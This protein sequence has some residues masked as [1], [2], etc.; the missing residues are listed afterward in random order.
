[1][2]RLMG[3]PTVDLLLMVCNLLRHFPYYLVI[4]SLLFVTYDW[5]GDL[6]QG[7]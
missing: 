2:Q 7:V 6:A 1:M 5:W 4:N 3:F